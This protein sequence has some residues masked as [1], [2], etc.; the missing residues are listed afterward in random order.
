MQEWFNPA[1]CRISLYYETTNKAFVY[2]I[3]KGFVVLSV[4]LVLV[5]L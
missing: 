1:S 2:R 3:S 5:T 4:S